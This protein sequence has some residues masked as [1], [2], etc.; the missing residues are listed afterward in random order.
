MTLQAIIALL[1]FSVVIETPAAIQ[2][3]WEA[4]GRTGNVAAY[5]TLDW[6]V[7]PPRNCTIHVPPLTP[8]TLNT[9]RHEIQHCRVGQ[10][11]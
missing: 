6:G 3:G 1:F 9:W 10:Y 7:S 2:A 5:A 8:E 11:H 4:L